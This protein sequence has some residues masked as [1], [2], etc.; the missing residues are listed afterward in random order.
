MGVQF[1]SIIKGRE[2]SLEDLSGKTIAV[3]AFNTLFQFLSIIRDRETGQPLMDSKG[4]ITSHL[5]GLFYRTAK[6][7]EAG[8]KPVYVFDGE[9]PKLKY[10]TVQERKEIRA[11]AEKDWKEALSVGDKEGA[12]KAAK[13]SSRLTG[14]MIEQSKKLLEYMGV[15]WIQAPSEAEAQ[16]AHMCK[17][18]QVWASASQDWDSIIF[19][20]PRLVRNLS[21]SGRRKVPGKEAYYELKPEIIDSKDFFEKVGMSREQMII[22][23]MLVGTD[24]NPGIKGIGP[25]RA[26]D[27]VKKEKTL[28]NVLSKI[29]WEGPSPQEVY[30]IFKNPPVKDVK[31]EPVSMDPEKIKKFLVHEFEFSPERIDKAV[32]NLQK[33]KPSKNSLSKWIK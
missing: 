27:L 10:N 24:F 14:E 28:E 17:E 25:K 18:K 31:I 19:G 23:A 29:Q 30:N 4:R 2:I 9:P 8:M 5:S 12:V 32:E 16:C 22:V 21:V 26:M 11:K 6:F 7:I 20:S 3:D 13:M 1:G 15:P 33:I